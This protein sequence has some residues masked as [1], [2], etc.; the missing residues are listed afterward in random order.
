MMVAL[1]KSSECHKGG[2]PSGAGYVD[3]GGVPS[4]TRQDGGGPMEQR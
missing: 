4:S 3:D 1:P 2:A